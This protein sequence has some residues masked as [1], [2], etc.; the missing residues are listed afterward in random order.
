MAMAPGEPLR[1][2]AGEMAPVGAGDVVRWTR[3]LVQS[4]DLF[5]LF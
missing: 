5:H 1:K 2:G 4:G 3:D